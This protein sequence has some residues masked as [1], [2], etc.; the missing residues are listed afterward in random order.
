[1]KFI[2]VSLGVVNHRRPRLQTSHFTDVGVAYSYTTGLGTLYPPSPGP[3][4]T[5]GPSESNSLSSRDACRDWFDIDFAV[6]RPAVVHKDD[7]GWIF[8][9]ERAETKRSRVDLRH[10]E[11]LAG[12]SAGLAVWYVSLA[13]VRFNWHVRGKQRPL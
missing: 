11:G 9:V 7:S 13:L 1:M 2:A 8:R 6:R 5:S 3:P 12:L 4:Q 10:F